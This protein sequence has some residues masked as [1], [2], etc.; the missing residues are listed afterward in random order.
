M[1]SLQRAPKATLVWLGRLGVWCS[2]VMGHYVRY[3]VTTVCA[4][5][6]L[7]IQIKLFVAGFDPLEP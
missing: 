3:L 4:D 1:I 7:A 5:G 6:Y 2:V